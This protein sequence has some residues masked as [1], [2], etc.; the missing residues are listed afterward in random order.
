MRLHIVYLE[1]DLELL[2]IPS[3]NGRKVTTWPVLGRAGG[4]AM[5]IN[6]QN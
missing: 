2:P 5:K 3:H 4:C 6:H 1:L